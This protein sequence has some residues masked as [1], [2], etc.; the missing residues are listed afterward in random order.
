MGAIDQAVG[1]PILDVL[2]PN[3][4]SGTLTLGALT[5]T[6]P[7]KCVF[8]STL[9]TAAANGT[10]IQ[11]G[12]SIAGLFTSAAASVSNVPTKSNTG[13]ISITVS[14]AGGTWAGCEIYDSTGTPKRVLYGPSSSLA[15]AYNTGDILAVNTGN[16]TGTVQ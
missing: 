14:G 8:T 5:L 3:G 9:G 15:K 11:A 4:S 6:L 1:N 2:L 10:A 16:A 12:V 13:T 7:F